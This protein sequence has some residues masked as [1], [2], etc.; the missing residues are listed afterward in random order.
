[1]NDSEFFVE[2]RKW[3]AEADATARKIRVLLEQLETDWGEQAAEL[4]LAIVRGM[5]HG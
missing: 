3:L 4:A 5:R 1:M 2:Q